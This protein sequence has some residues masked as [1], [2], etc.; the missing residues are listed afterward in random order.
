MNFTELVQQKGQLHCTVDF[1]PD[2]TERNQRF[3]AIEKLSMSLRS[4]LY[5][6]ITRFYHHTLYL[7]H[8]VN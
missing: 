1:C 7:Y 4:N 5:T 2:H 3:K 6:G 8:A